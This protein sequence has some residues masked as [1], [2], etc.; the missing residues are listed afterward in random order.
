MPW[1]GAAQTHHPNETFIPSCPDRLKDLVSAGCSS[2]Y[3]PSPGSDDTV[4]ET[5][6]GGQGPGSRGHKRGHLAFSLRVK[7]VVSRGQHGKPAGG[8]VR[9][10]FRESSIEE[11]EGTRGEGA[12]DRSGRR[13][14]KG[15]ITGE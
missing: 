12:G 5:F 14:Q 10:C 3:G 2:G 13:P 15:S 9:P 8:T 11:E 6:F 7:G 1:E 4:M